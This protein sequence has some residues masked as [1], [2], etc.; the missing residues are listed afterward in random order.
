MFSKVVFELTPHSDQGRLVRQSCHLALVPNGSRL[1]TL[2]PLTPRAPGHQSE[3][4]NPSRS[5]RQN[6]HGSEDHREQE[7]DG[8]WQAA[9]E[10][11]EVHL[12]AV[13]VLKNED[14]DHDQRQ[15]ADH[16][17]GPGAAESGLALARVGSGPLWRLLRPCFRTWW[18]A[19]RP[20][21]MPANAKPATSKIP[22]RPADQMATEAATRSL[23]LKRL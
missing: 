19:H 15:D 4:K 14:K 1:W 11:K 12:H 13:E 20:D 17:G 22:S 21:C 8:Q 2:R 7:R 3:L 10:D 6:D 5:E 23:A 9:L 18:R 16:Q